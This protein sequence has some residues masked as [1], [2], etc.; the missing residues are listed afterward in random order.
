M[1]SKPKIYCWINSGHGTDMQFTVAMAEDGTCLGQ[2]ASSSEAWA[3]SD[4]GVYGETNVSARKLTAMRE[5]Y[6]GGFDLVWLDDPR[7][8]PGWRR[9]AELNHTMGERARQADAE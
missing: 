2:H 8:D 7:S 5:H 9:A 3:K 4:L 1:P 6:P